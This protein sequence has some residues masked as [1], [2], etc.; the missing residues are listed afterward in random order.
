[1][2]VYQDIKICACLVALLSESLEGKY[3]PIKHIRTLTFMVGTVQE[4]DANILRVSFSVPSF[5]GDH[6]FLLAS[7]HGL[8]VS[9]Q[10]PVRP[11]FFIFIRTSTCLPKPSYLEHAQSPRLGRGR[12]HGRAV[13]PQRQRPDVPRIAA[14]RQADGCRLL[15]CRGVASR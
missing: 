10:S 8:S 4:K 13:D 9:C 11:V 1:M 6:V 3:L 5:A 14:I 15:R 2:Y 12:R 7:C